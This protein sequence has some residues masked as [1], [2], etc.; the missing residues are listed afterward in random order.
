MGQGSE[1]QLSSPQLPTAAILA[2][3]GLLQLSH[4]SISEKITSKITPANFRPFPLRCLSIWHTTATAPGLDSGNPLKGTY[5]QDPP[6]LS[7]CLA[8]RSFAKGDNCLSC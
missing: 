4:A 2:T 1:E 8:M 7:G 6:L 3:L 5:Q